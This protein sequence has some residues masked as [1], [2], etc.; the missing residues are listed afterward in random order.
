MNKMLQTKISQYIYLFQLIL[1][2]FCPCRSNVTTL[3][4][5]GCG[6]KR[7]G[8]DI[9]IFPVLILKRD[10]SPTVSNAYPQPCYGTRPY[11]STCSSLRLSLAGELR[12][13]TACVTR[14]WAGRDNAIL[15]EPTSSHGNCLKTRR[16]PPVGCTLCWAAEF[17]GMR[18]PNDQQLSHLHKCNPKVVDS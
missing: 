1:W 10:I 11:V 18:V 6:F 5:R 7:L 17:I 4:R 8:G 13:P 14:W 15:T 16:L 2:M 9:S 12:R 3:R